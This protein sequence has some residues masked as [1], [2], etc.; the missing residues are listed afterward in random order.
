MPAPTAVGNSA[1][2]AS[3]AHQP[4][5]Y[6]GERSMTSFRGIRSQADFEQTERRRVAQ[7]DSDEGQEA[8]LG[9]R[10]KSSVPMQPVAA[11]KSTAAAGDAVATNSATSIGP[12]MKMSS[13]STDSSEY[14]VARRV[15]SFRRCLK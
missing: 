2:G 7:D 10:R 15:S 6:A 9:E 11:A 5:Q 12:T 1:Q 3:R 13:I 14:A 8:A 4:E